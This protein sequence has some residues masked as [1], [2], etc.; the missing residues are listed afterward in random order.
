MTKIGLI[1]NNKLTY[2][3]FPYNPNDNYPEF[4]NQYKPQ[5]DNI[6][7]KE[8]RDLFIK[9]GYDKNNAN[10][11]DWNP[12]GFLIKA[13]DRVLIKP[14]L[15]I[16]YQRNPF[17]VITHPS[18]IRFL[19]DYVN[20]ALKKSGE[21]VIGDAPQNNADLNKL[22]KYTKIDKLVDF[23]K[24][25]KITV[26]FIDFR[27]DYVQMKY[28]I[29]IRR[30]KLN[31]DPL[32]YKIIDLKENSF[33]IDVEKEKKS[34]FYGS[35]YNRKLV[36]YNHNVK[37]N[38]YCI[39]KTVLNSN[40][41][42]S[43]PKL[44][45]HKKTG[46]TLNLKN[47]IGINVNKNFLPHYRINSPKKEGDSYPS[48]NSFLDF[49]RK[50]RYFFRD[51]FLSN[52]HSKVGKI[53]FKLF[54]KRGYIEYII[55]K[56]FFPR[57]LF[58]YQNLIDGDWFGNDTIW[59]AI[60]DL[61]KIVMYTDYKGDL[62]SSKQRRF[63]SVIDGIISGEKN[64]PLTPDPKNTCTILI[65]DNLLLTDIV[66]TKI[67]GFDYKKIPLY[68]NALKVKF[69][70]ISEENIK[71]IHIVS[72]NKKYNN[73]SYENLSLNFEFTPPNGWPNLKNH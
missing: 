19:I 49:T 31:S 70:T 21:I 72:N 42:I 12:L 6:L 47:F 65:G 41:I 56:I 2:P 28:G 32:S 35:D 52:Y 69:D 33:L 55:I 24:E 8:L 39:S 11:K 57:F 40:V 63:F 29:G 51:L 48:I 43:V 14:N 58:K 66:A 7:Y 68:K 30:K 16:D 45:T 22:L 62:N 37:R 3:K 13:G 5:P 27:G 10:T 15:V 17:C 38:A 36:N 4:D 61:N 50:L 20:I 23:L 71:N 60:L 46:V 64:G 59:R 18:I 53:F 1:Y 44:K 9:M 34:N 73:I 54:E 25:K 67:I 26:K